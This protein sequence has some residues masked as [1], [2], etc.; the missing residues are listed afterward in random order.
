AIVITVGVYGTVGLIV[1][2]DDICLH[3]RRSSSGLLRTIGR[4]LVTGMP[5]LL[6]VLSIVG[7]FVMLWVGGHIILVGLAEDPITWPVLYDL[8]HHL[9]VSVA[10]ATGAFGGILGWATNTIGS[11]ILGVL[12]GGAVVA[13]VHVL[14]FGDRAGP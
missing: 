14:P 11:M 13:I 3:L 4:G 9:E 10:D 5:M 7:V 8:V 6:S 2:M 1:K 12:V